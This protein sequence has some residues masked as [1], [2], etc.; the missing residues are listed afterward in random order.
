[1]YHILYISN[2]YEYFPCMKKGKYKRGE[3]KKPDA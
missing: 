1:M 3:Y 2:K